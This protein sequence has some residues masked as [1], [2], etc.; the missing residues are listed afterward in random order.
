MKKT[1]GLVG[2]AA[3]TL[4]SSFSAMPALASNSDCGPTPSGGTLTE[5]NGVCT[6]KFTTAGSYTFTTPATISNLAAVSIGGGGGLAYYDANGG[7]DYGY[8]GNAGGV[9]YA[10]FTQVE[11]G[12]V[13]QI[14]VGEGG[15]TALNT[16]S[17]GTASTISSGS[18][19]LTGAG[20]T[21][22]GQ[23]TYC[24][25]GPNSYNGV[26]EG[27]GGN[28]T[29]RAGETCSQAPGYNFSAVFPSLFPTNDITIGL[30][31]MM[32]NTPS[33]PA[34]AP[35]SGAGG[36]LTSTEPNTWVSRDAAGADGGAFFRWRIAGLANTGTNANSTTGFATGTI[37]LGTGLIAASAIRRRNAPKHRA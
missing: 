35:G 15:A 23:N 7:W 31:G 1:L 4:G 14:V 37:L 10:D 32:Y 28:T 33:R 6:L 18:Q 17:S 12:R 25:L 27:A 16:P 29:S 9:D 13:F 5:S 19:T 36:S 11:Q 20:G 30:G 3:V 2:L 26:G 24:S 22:S 34:L 21:P 8:A